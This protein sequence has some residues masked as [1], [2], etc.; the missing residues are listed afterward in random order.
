L[1]ENRGLQY[2]LYFT[3]LVVIGIVDKDGNTILN[4]G[5]N[6]LLKPD[7]K[8]ILIGSSDQLSLFEEKAI[9]DL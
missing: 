8:V 9:N 2:I 4:P 7:S 5:P 3:A 1:I 6:E